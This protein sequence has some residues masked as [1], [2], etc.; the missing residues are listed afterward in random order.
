MILINTD[1]IL[2]TLLSLPLL[3][4]LTF[5]F[6]A[7]VTFTTINTFYCSKSLSLSLSLSWFTCWSRVLEK[8]ELLSELDYHCKK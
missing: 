8:G 4:S 3:M 1:N 2:L 7:T 6:D 5:L